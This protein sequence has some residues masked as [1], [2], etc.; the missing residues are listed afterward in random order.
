MKSGL[1]EAVEILSGV[2]GIGHIVFKEAD[3]VRH[4]LVRRIVAAYEANGR[5]NQGAEKPPR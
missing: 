2:E 4:D 5:R 1:R 3:V